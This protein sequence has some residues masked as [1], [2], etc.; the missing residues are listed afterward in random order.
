[1]VQILAKMPRNLSEENFSQ[2]LFMRNERTML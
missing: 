2:F 1:M